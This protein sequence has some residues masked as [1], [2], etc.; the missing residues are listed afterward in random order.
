[1]EPRDLISAITRLQHCRD[2]G[3]TFIDGR[4][5]EIFL[6]Y[7]DLYAEA[8]TVLGAL[9]A[10][11][12]RQGDELVFQI[13]DNK[14]FV[15]LFW[16]CL[17][18]GI[19]PVPL[20]LAQNDD[21]QRKL[22]TV[23]PVLKN[24][25]LVIA[26]K[27]RER[28][29]TFVST[30]RLQ[31][32]YNRLEGHIV[33]VQELF[34]ESHDGVVVKVQEEDIAFIQFSS[35][36]TGSPKG[37]VLTHRNLITNVKAIA[38]AAAYSPADTLFSWMPLTHD[39]GLIGFHINPLYCGI[40]HCI[41]STNLFIRVPAL[42]I[43]KAS[44]HRATVLCSPNFGFRYLMK[45]IERNETYRWDL[46]AVRII[47]NGAEPISENNCRAFADALAT[48]KL[49]KYVVRPVYG[50]AEA[51]LAVTMTALG[52]DIEVLHLQREHLGAGDKIVADTKGVSFVNVGKP[53]NDCLLRI[54]DDND[55]V[56]TEGV[57]GQIEIKG[58]NVTRGYYHNDAATKHAI[59][60]D[61][62]L[63]TGDL[64]FISNGSLYI[65]GRIKD[66]V[67]VNGQNYYAHDIER[68]AEGIEGIDL[69]R[70][71]VGSVQDEATAQEL[72]IA[73]VFHRGG[74]DK[75]VAVARNLRA[76]VLAQAGL[77]LSSIIPVKE[78][79]RT[80]SG[81]L[82]RFKILDD[83]KRGVLSKEEA[84]LVALMTPVNHTSGES[85]PVGEPE[86]KLRNIW[87][88][89]L[90][91]DDF[92]AMR[93]FF[94]V[95]GN[96]LK[97]AQMAMMIH[98]EFGVELPMEVIF[99]KQTIKDLQQEIAKR[100]Q[101]AYTPI[102]AAPLQ[103]YYP[104]SFA[105]RGIY[106]AWMANRQSTAYNIPVAFDLGSKPDVAKLE[107]SLASLVRRHA[108]LRA[109]FLH[110]ETPALK[111]HEQVPVTLH[112]IAV[113]AGDLETRL[114][115]L[116]KPFDLGV[117]PLFR[118]ALLTTG[119]GHHVL[120]ADFHHSIADGV[121]ISTF[122]NEL[123][124]LY[125]GETLTPLAASYKDFVV[126]QSAMTTEIVNRHDAYW[127]LQLEDNPL[128]EM[129]GDFA[130]PAI[131]DHAGAKIEF[132]LDA[133]ITK[134]L[135]QM[136]SQYQLTLHA[137]LSSVYAVMLSRY[138]GQDEV[139]YGI[140]VSGRTHADMQEMVGMFVNSLP[141]RESISGNDAFLNIAQQHQAR[142]RETLAHQDYPFENLVKKAGGRRD[143]SR[144]VLFDTMFIYQNMDMPAPE[145]SGLRLS[146]RFFDPGFSKYDISVE[147]FEEQHS[148]TYAVEYSTRLFEP[149]TIENFGRCLKKLIEAVVANPLQKVSNLSLEDYVAT[150]VVR[151]A[152]QLPPYPTV[153]DWF[154][155]QTLKTPDRLAVAY[156]AE[157]LTYAELSQYVHR[158]AFE[159]VSRGVK[160]GSAVGILLGRSPE[161]VAS[162]LAVMKTGA[163][164]VPIDM[165]LPSDRVRYML[166]HSGCRV[167]ITEKDS[168]SAV[169]NIS[170]AGII[171]ADVLSSD[172][173]RVG[174]IPHRAEASDVA[175]IIYTSGTTGR[176]KGVMIEHRSLVSYIN[177]AAEEYVGEEV[178][179]FP[180]FTSIS[181]DL[182]LTSIFTP[183][184]TGGTIV[185]YPDDKNEV[186]AV[187]VVRDNCSTVVKLTPSHLRLLLDCGALDMEG[188]KIKRFVVGGEALERSLAQA[189]TDKFG[190][191]IAIYNEYGPTEAT[192][193][194]M[195]HRFTPEEQT[196][197]VPIGY[198]AV[199]A[200]IFILDRYLKPV[201]QGARGEI[202]IGGTCLAR[203]YV[204]DARLT[205]E[206][207]VNVASCGGKR[208]Y[209][210]GDEA[211]QLANGRLIYLGRLD[212]Q[213][214]I[215]GYRIE[216][217]EIE[218]QLMK[219]PAVQS[220]VV[221][222][223]IDARGHK[224]L[225]A[226]YTLV[227]G[228]QTCTEQQLRIFLADKLP[229]Y[230]IPVYF[231]GVTEIPVTRNGKV[232]Y[233]AL[234][235][236]VR[237]LGEVLKSEAE[238][239]LQALV[240][241]T[242]KNVFRIP[243]LGMDDNFLE[244]GGDS[245]KA[246]QITAR[247][248]DKGL[249]ARTKDI[250][251][252][253]TVRQL[254]ASGVI[255]RSGA[256]YDQG[257]ASGDRE[258]TPIER[259]FFAQRF[260]NPNF[261][262]QSVV[263]KIKG[264][265]RLPL[266][267]K[268]FAT[269]VHH[270]DALRA[271]YDSQRGRMFYNDAHLGTP[272]HIQ[273]IS[274]E[275]PFEAA[276]R[277]VKKSFDIGSGLLIKA[278]IWQ[279]ELLLITAHHLVIDGVSWRILLHDLAVVY[280]ALEQSQP[281]HLSPKTASINHWL[282]ALAAYER[283]ISTQASY[284][285]TSLDSEFEVE[286][287]FHSKDW[288]NKNAAT[289]SGSLDED[290][291]REL[292]K[293]THHHY[294][295]E[296]NV[297]LNTA[298]A[299][300]LKDITGSHTVVIEQENH[301]RH[302]DGVDA[303]NTIGWFTAMY[304]LKLV[305]EPNSLAQQIESV[306]NQMREIPDHGLGY[307]AG[308][309][310]EDNYSRAEMRL[311]YLGQFSDEVDNTLWQWCM[312][313]SGSDVDGENHMTAKLDINCLVIHGRFE[314]TLTYHALTYSKEKMEFVR[315]R[316]FHHL[317]AILALLASGIEIQPVAADFDAALSVED[318]KEIFG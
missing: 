151:G 276:C 189:V 70:V 67:I 40:N 64:G 95:G 177:W 206:R 119:D 106:Y 45:Y 175:Y 161:L 28:L 242:W 187:K 43:D 158:F 146:R 49:P 83:Y 47:Y 240:L 192:V 223:V 198:A 219:H 78:I 273:E 170:G 1:V 317:R 142:I 235:Q 249:S 299:L 46:S 126:W 103:E 197:T 77:E 302:L 101:A 233:T 98:R 97:A 157:K 247:L 57:I 31:Q 220:A 154:E 51:S 102:P 134:A 42:W 80:T 279:D 258:L 263:L 26:Q 112:S 295:A 183:L 160:K 116:V 195:I 155:A 176:P 265:L 278:M 91:H 217:H 290:E 210:T 196:P 11:G 50:L 215:N 173:A 104:L 36:S 236:P 179:S 246:V 296:A 8:R 214:K 120:F 300:T 82:Q 6:C 289:V 224:M 256:Q 244:L 59:T 174:F 69:N 288:C 133:S 84:E 230:M 10:G 16:A 86:M 109:S 79:P 216:L 260:A 22:F 53:V 171:Y 185:V 115:S 9:Q 130:R 310:Y 19:I 228:Q 61:G 291:T 63:K 71:I 15:T 35:G 318:L 168:A 283:T 111:F 182:T 68:L 209:K 286:T 204:N 14:T 122:I 54:A 150:G 213:V 225:C 162:V 301:G 89:L 113:N 306:K 38:N 186:L 237:Q 41:M 124:R 222:D 81:K 202:Y 20:S 65:T 164:F 262:N 231:V 123:C 251:T 287:D 99:E 143:T 156:N 62:W 85:L 139:V 274:G 72:A 74:L 190:G 87:R 167:L 226:Y 12:L 5:Q 58:N 153:Y 280:Q 75:F 308:K 110:G 18:G 269:L 284:W 148:L 191:D 264:P 199:N 121:S 181:F 138:T 135:R 129:P 136:A 25:Y 254:C 314:W 313:N 141:V 21:H 169:K 88:E 194:C 100:G 108:I 221:K 117:A 39:M 132:T 245:I 17:L 261:F 145:Q 294:K 255:V 55:A 165:D 159:L 52:E 241:D 105:Q 232:N 315:D 13:G 178:C 193:G 44:E 257:L 201:P 312:R 303:S 184:V 73:F 268:A 271:N 234:P 27:D 163:C 93:R 4:D 152:R 56:V 307:L 172:A 229:H 166:E 316:F 131:F 149:V 267:E 3:I 282:T 188:K 140:P 203:G 285:Q 292:L 66:L 293:N 137:V 114:K 147:F 238:D 90:R 208:L 128:L 309:K 34:F 304:P 227:D 23:L 29:D 298:L 259:W 33:D 272:F 96:S 248:S 250:L 243:S 180:L 7:R 30:Q 92:T 37:V 2:T 253:Q 76:H 252:Y 281:V 107:Q 270:H 205:G 125:R 311:N 207:F 24:P 239:A 277:Q 297:L 212:Q 200:E 94:E 144:N 48:Y 266:L 60:A 32:Q 275:M 118:F 305:L 127:T 218:Q 211:R